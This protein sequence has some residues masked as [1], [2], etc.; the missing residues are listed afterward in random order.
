M[1]GFKQWYAEV[2]RELDRLS[3]NPDE[4]DSDELW[5]G[6]TDGET[7][8]EFAA[9]LKRLCDDAAADTMNLN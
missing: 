2:R 9:G 8:A 7:P 3:M 6:Y 4:P 1:S 5:E